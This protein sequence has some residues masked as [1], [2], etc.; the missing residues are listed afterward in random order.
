MNLR[1]QVQVVLFVFGLAPL[2]ALLL[3]NFPMVYERMQGFYQSAYLQN[4]RAEFNDLDQHLATRKES[5]RWVAKIPEP[6]VINTI[7]ASTGLTDEEK[8]QQRS[9]YITWMNHVLYD[10]LDIIEIQFFSNDGAPLLTLARNPRNLKFVE[11]KASIIKTGSKILK[12]AMAVPAG[13]ILS[14][15]IQL[16]ESAIDLDPRY[17]MTSQLIGPLIN[18]QQDRNKNIVAKTAGAVSVRIDVS[19]L[20]RAFP[21]TS[22]VLNDG[23]YANTVDYK[24]KNAFDEF[25]GLKTLFDNGKMDLLDSGLDK[26]VFWA[27]LFLTE[28]HG[29]LWVGR[30][31]DP[32]AINTFNR[33][34]LG[35][36]VIIVAGVLMLVWIVARLIASRMSRVSKELINGVS[37]VMTENKP[38][39]FNW[40]NP[41]ELKEL[42]Q[43][44]DE[45]SKSHIANIEDI[46][47]H[48]REL[49]DSNRYKSEFLANVS[50]ELRTP[51]NSILLLSRLLSQNNEG[52]LQ[53]EQKQ[54][55][56]VINNAGNDL[57]V[58][59][60]NILDLS[61]IEA[62]RCEIHLE[63][64]DIS[65]IAEDVI[66]VMGPQFEQKGIPLVYE[67]V[68]DTLIDSDGDKIK[69]ILLNFIANALKFTSSGEVRIRVEKNPQY[70]GR[71]WA[72]VISIA[73]QGIGIDADKLKT[74]F[75]AFT[76]ADGST[77]R[78]Y[79]GTGLGLTICRQ[80][81]QLLE[82]EIAVTSTP[83]AGS[84]FSLYLPAMITNQSSTDKTPGDQSV[85]TELT[86]PEATVGLE[87]KRLLIVDDDIRSI[88]SLKLVLDSWGIE[89]MAAADAQEADETL[90]SEPEF[91]FLMIACDS[92]DTDAVSKTLERYRKAEI[93]A[94]RIIV[95]LNE[96][97]DQ[98]ETRC[99]Q[100]GADA[101]VYKPLDMEQLRLILSD[102]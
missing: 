30:I 13:G 71:T 43:K 9:G 35:R 36:L 14:G 48:T 32:S 49:E 53:L 62:G 66:S 100:A 27:P 84:C 33:R 11:V 78:R 54:Q 68:D 92:C 25:D 95:L 39:A 40:N 94:N 58:L 45:L 65:S 20:A 23:R 76:Q 8:R 38:V 101:V 98:A 6:G 77:S 74:I 24:S 1:G 15:P 82:A 46:H 41:V 93:H 80:L 5:L 10:Q 42:G 57:K 69:Q 64:I 44:L 3:L 90:S 86:A 26:P 83:G 22:W 12:S 28:T 81:A 99:K 63:R 19:G 2:L 102:L 91:E 16:N 67:Q 37:D 56:Q 60:D 50:H 4:L 79:G 87:G 97:T 47:K 70:R 34:M 55:A 61:R 31:V 29:P 17:F 72:A 88:L 89:S 7:S 75:E 73:D 21:N 85:Q 52:N 51:L 18:L 59:I 96:K